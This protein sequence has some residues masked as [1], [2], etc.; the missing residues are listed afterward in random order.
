MLAQGVINPSTSPWPSPVVLVRKKDGTHLFCVD[1][2]G[3]NKVN[4]H[5]AYPLPRIDD[6]LDSLSG[7]MWF[8]VLDGRSA[9]SAHPND[10]LK[11]LY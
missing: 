1:S 9:I 10:R 8:S 7:H 4:T 11:T 3:L 6:I 2:R 5:D